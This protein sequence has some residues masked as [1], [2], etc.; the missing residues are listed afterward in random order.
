M[1]A[2][3]GIVRDQRFLDH[4]TGLTHPERPARLEAIHRRLDQ[5]L[6]QRL[7]LVEPV[8]ASL[9]MLELVHRPAYIE[10]VLRTAR[11]GH[12]HL[13]S[14]T[15]ASAGTHRAACL[16]AGGCVQ[17]L[18]RLLA[19]RLDACFALVRPPGHHALPDQAGGFCVFNNLG[20]AAR[21]GLERLG[22][23][24][25]LIVDWDIHHGNALQELFYEDPR[26]FYFSSHY[27]DSYPHTGD[28]EAVG[29]GPGR[30]YTLNLPLPKQMGDDEM[31]RLYR[32]VLPAVVEGFQPQVIMVA[33]GFDA[34]R[35]DP[36]GRGDMTERG[37]AA[38]AALV[39]HLGPERGVPLL[40][41]LEGGYQPAALAE[42]VAGVL[43]VLLDGAEPG[44][45]QE[46]R[47]ERGA[48]L[49]ARARE[50][51]RPYGIWCGRRDS[52]AGGAG[53]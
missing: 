27:L 37:F 13:A 51:H 36:L 40:L 34:H 44:L 10:M 21:Y 50:I 46:P 5:G 3:V 18:R 14:D 39:R 22:L 28:W 29:H 53:A 15:P 26:A 12:V 6:A 1:K 41:A 19:G 33:A 9:E 16:A 30:G 49:A 11:L 38:L 23:E 24:R 25:I 52:A 48:E 20:I 42:S 43:Q 31:I 45:W 32:E 17:A 4:Q 35:D 8:M 2:R 47:G 7:E